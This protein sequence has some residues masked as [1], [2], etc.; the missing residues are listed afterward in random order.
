MAP[1]QANFRELLKIAVPLM[2]SLLSMGLVIFLDRLILSYYST[3]AMNAVIGV[4]M[5]I[6]VFTLALNL[7][8]LTGAVF[9]GQYNGAGEKDQI[10]GVVWQIIWFSLFSIPFFFGT[11]FL[12]PY[13]FQ[14]E[15]EY[16]QYILPY[17]EISVMFS[18]L[19]PM[20]SAIVSFFLGIG[21]TFPI[22]WV[23]VVSKV[24]QI[25][26]EIPLVFALGTKGAAIAI[27]I[28]QVVQIVLF[29]I[30]FL[31]KKNRDTYGTLNWKFNPVIFRRWL[32]IGFPNAIEPFVS[33]G[34][35]AMLANL[36]LAY[37]KPDTITIFN[38]AQNYLALF[39]FSFAAV[40]KALTSITANLIGS[41]HWDQI[42]KAI[43]SASL[44]V[45]LMLGVIAIPM[46]FFPDV[47]IG[48]FTSHVSPIAKETLWFVLLNILIYGIGWI[49]GSVL[50]GGGDTK[51]VMFSSLFIFIVFAGAPIFML[52]T[53][54]GGD[55]ILTMATMCIYSAINGVNF[56]LRYKGSSWRHIRVI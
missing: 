24:I 18:F 11:K 3:D 26:L 6:G 28:S 44:L 51:Y 4:S 1:I 19:Y 33:F 30:L 14:W 23:T 31:R 49:F 25:G 21:A 20:A 46:F 12:G 40:H 37:D 56:Y 2:F 9:V 15:G 13:L 42:P 34:I 53:R 32:N 45:I 27:V 16:L 29:L 22:L 43:R 35:L 47:L 39:T 52:V 48:I 7:I 10:G 55:P 8:A 36:R 5:F 38:I 41:N 50:I 54:F 17:F